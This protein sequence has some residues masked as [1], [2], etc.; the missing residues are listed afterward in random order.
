MVAAEESGFARVEMWDVYLV[1]ARS[2]LFE[3]CR[4]TCGA[5]GGRRVNVTDS[6]SANSLLTLITLLNVSTMIV[7]QFCRMYVMLYCYTIKS[8][9]QFFTLE[10]PRESICPQKWYSWNQ[11]YGIW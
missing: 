11:R 7:S 6:D 9:G 2:N 8:R 4:W 3:A 1:K 5:E 10:L